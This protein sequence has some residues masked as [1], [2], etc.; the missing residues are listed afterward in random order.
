MKSRRREGRR[1]YA[2]AAMETCLRTSARSVVAMA[3]VV[4]LIVG[5]A[6]S[7]QA[8]QLVRTPLGLAPPGSSSV[9]LGCAAAVFGGPRG[10]GS[11]SPANG[12]L[13]GGPIAWPVLRRF[14]SQLPASRYAPHHAL[15]PGIKAL[16]A[17]RTGA[18]VRVVVPS[19]ERTR[20]S[21]DYTTL[22][23]R[24]LIGGYAY[25]RVADGASSVTFRAC[26]L[27]TGNGPQTPLAGY[28]LVSGRQCARINIYTS[29]S[30]TP[31]QRQIPF[32]VSQSSC[33]AA[34]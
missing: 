11:L 26:S 13:V 14:A 34:G 7:V 30:T 15:A 4:A 1:A 29:A 2:V 5:S 18:V 32:G 19:S 23:P 20:L 12:T 24:A 6:S 22:P 9:T 27:G 10:V 28:F 33:P 17:V 31:I 8:Q 21:L 25:F 3:A 16:V